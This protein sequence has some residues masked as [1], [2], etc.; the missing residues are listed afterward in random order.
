[1]N[2]NEVKVVYNANH[3]GFSLSHMAA[4]WLAQR[5]ENSA[6]EWL[7]SNSDAFDQSFYPWSDEIERH[8][9]LLVQCVE[10]LGKKAWG[11]PAE[12]K[13]KV[14]KGDRYIINDYDGLET[15][16]EPHD[17]KWTIVE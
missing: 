2:N 5:G 1:M 9:P 11:A 3:G 7:A 10:T 14:L 16:T 13:I 12:L 17:I 4:M 6:I 8:D 15:V